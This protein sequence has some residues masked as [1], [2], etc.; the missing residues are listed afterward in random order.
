MGFPLSLTVTLM[1]VV[2]VLFATGLKLIEPVEFEL[3]KLTVG[4]GIR[5]V[6]F[7]A[8]VTVTI[9][10]PNGSPEEIPV[11]EIVCNPAF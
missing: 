6:S 10:L 4:F 7:D 3:A 8:A 11:S 9:W 5:V 1:T 2:P